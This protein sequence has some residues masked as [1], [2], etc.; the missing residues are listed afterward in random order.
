MINGTSE[1]FRYRRHRQNEWGGDYFESVRS[2][3]DLDL[4][5]NRLIRLMGT[6]INRAPS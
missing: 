5:E 6:E 4:G 1:T 3:R 2:D